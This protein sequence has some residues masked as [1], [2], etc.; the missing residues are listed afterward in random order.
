M[1][2]LKSV[3]ELRGVT[4]KAVAEHLGVARQTYAN[5]ESKQEKM[6]VEQAKAACDFLHCEVADV[7]CIAKWQMFF[8]LKRSSRQT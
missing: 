8:Y 3:R 4:Q 5:Y 1:Q 6:T 2:T 7:S